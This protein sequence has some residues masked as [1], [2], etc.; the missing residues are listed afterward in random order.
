MFYFLDKIIF[1]LAWKSYFVKSL[2]FFK[3]IKFFF[4]VL[5]FLQSD[6]FT[7]FTL[8]LPTDINDNDTTIFTLHCYN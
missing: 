4:Y 6:Y 7:Y 2:A 1:S 5:K 8:Y 3:G